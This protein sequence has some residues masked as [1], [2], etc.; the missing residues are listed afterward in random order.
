[1]NRTKNLIKLILTFVY[2]FSTFAFNA[3][4]YASAASITL[5]VSPTEVLINDTGDVTLE[6]VPATIMNNGDTITINYP[7]S[8][9]DDAVGNELV[10]GDFYFDVASVSKG[11]DAGLTDVSASVDRGNNI[12]VLTLTTGVALNTTDAFSIIFPG[13]H[14]NA[15][16]SADSVS[17]VVTSSVGDYGAALQYVGDDNDVTVTATVQPILAFNIRNEFDTDDTNVCPLGILTVATIE[18]CAYR[19]KVTTNLEN[20]YVIY[21]SSDGDLRKSGSGAVD[22]AENIDSTIRLRSRY[23]D[24][25]M[26]I[27]Y[28]LDTYVDI[29]TEGYGINVDE[30]SITSGGIINATCTIPGFGSYYIT[31]CYDRDDAPLQIDETPMINSTGSNNPASTDLVNTVL[32]THVAA[33][34]ADTNTGNYQQIVTYTVTSNF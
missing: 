33:I 5:S 4:N 21:Q 10:A 31:D 30:G 19:L 15:P 23:W 28:N 18:E 1:M 12:V 2:T 6:F 7:D 3:N 20:G 27:T 14:F 32:V 26:W 13:A 25:E 24:G 9:V 17:F 22:D 34:D 16:A 11:S 29:G 8:Y